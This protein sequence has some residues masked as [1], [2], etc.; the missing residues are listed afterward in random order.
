MSQNRAYDHQSDR[1]VLAL[2]RLAVGDDQSSVGTLA[3]LQKAMLI[4]RDEFARL[5]VPTAHTTE[6]GY[7]IHDF[8]MLPCQLHQ[9][10]LNCDE[11]VCIKGD[12]VREA[13]RRR[14]RDET[15]TLL[16]AAEAAVAEAFAGAD[17]WR[18]HQRKTLE[19]LDQLCGILDDPC[20]PS[21]TVIRNRAIEHT[22]SASRSRRT[23]GVGRIATVEQDRQC[24]MEVPGIVRR[25]SAGALSCH[26]PGF[27]IALCWLA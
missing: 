7:C 15:R 4:R 1:D 17:R 3:H 19:R 13:N 25:G 6:F 22:V 18:E 2:V 12:V 11:Q 10:C 24:P 20:I 8:S 23:G 9:D 5:K 16:A 14:H 27:V 21:G 26:Q